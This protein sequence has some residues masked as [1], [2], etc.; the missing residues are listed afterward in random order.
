MN[1]WLIAIGEILPIEKEKRKTRTTLLAEKLIER[2]HNVLWWTSA[3]DHFKK[4]W[5]F[6]KDTTLS[7]GKNL[8]IK[9]LK[10]LGY[11]KNFSLERYLDHRIITLKFKKL[12][13]KEPKPDII[14]TSM[15]SHD[16]AYQAVIFAKKNKIPVV[17]D[18]RDK[19]PDIFF[20]YFP[21]WMNPLVKVF[22]YKD[23][24]MVNYCFKNATHIV[25]MMESILNWAL[26]K[27]ERKRT[28][29]DR[30]FYL[31]AEKI[32]QVPKIEKLSFIEKLTKNKFVITFIG[33][34]NE[35]YNP[36]ILTKAAEILSNLNIHFILGGDGIYFSKVKEA[37]RKLKNVSLTGWLSNEE[38][39]FILSLSNIGIIPSTKKVEA[40]PNKAFVYLSAGLPIVSSVEGDLKELIKKYN[41]GLYYPPND[42]GLL[43][44]C[45][46]KL[47]EDRSLYE[48]MSWNAKEIFNKFLDA[49]KIYNEYAEYVEEI[50]L[51]YRNSH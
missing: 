48:K 2:G 14:V 22:L 23:F 33:A 8:R 35:T 40:F 11:K 9:A 45:I 49:E 24:Q 46:K 36:L 42:L 38:I 32:G 34:F 16:L 31:G 29:D 27:T 21:R 28:L 25:S 37:S 43:V 19:W 30:V 1:I 4:K 6:G 39:H 7:L 18:V 44:E 10:G 12:A 41:I 13:P 5:I 20:E 3:F 17:V 15:P 26:E 47:Y 50:E 51:K